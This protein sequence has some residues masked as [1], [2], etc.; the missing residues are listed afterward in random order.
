MALA[1]SRAM[2]NASR[3]V[4]GTRR[5][6]RAPRRPPPPRPPAGFAGAEGCGG[7]PAGG[8]GGGGAGAARA[9]RAAAPPLLL[10]EGPYRRACR[11]PPYEA[12]SGVAC[13]TSHLNIR[14]ALRQ[15]LRQ[16][17]RTRYEAAQQL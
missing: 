3:S 12:K 11:E 14:S 15:S 6:S 16:C 13:E 1:T 2:T 17:L 7:E 10:R 5:P 4:K 8:G 9:A